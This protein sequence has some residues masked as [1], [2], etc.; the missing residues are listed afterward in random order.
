[1]DKFNYSICWP[2]G[3]DFSPDTLYE[4]GKDF[5][6]KR[7]TSPKRQPATKQPSIRKQGLQF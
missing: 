6:N 5:Q 2:N 7:R 4:A 1:M 3:A